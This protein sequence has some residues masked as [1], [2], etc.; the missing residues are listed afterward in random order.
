MLQSELKQFTLGQLLPA[1]NYKAR[2]ARAFNVAIPSETTRLY[3]ELP[4]QSKK[5][6]AGS[7]QNLTP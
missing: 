3:R 6:K 5:A 7:S 2:L 1:A 4:R